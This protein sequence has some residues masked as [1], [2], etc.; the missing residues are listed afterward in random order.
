M[1]SFSDSTSS[2]GASAQAWP[3]QTPEV[4]VRDETFRHEVRDWLS[5][6]L[7][8]EFAGLR[9]LG[10]P[11]R[12]HEAFDLRVGWDRHLAASGWTCLGWPVE[13]GGR[14]LPLD[15][16]VVFH[17]EYARSGAPARVSH[18]GEELRG[19]LMLS[20]TLRAKQCQNK[21]LAR[22]QWH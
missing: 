9:G 12:E 4:L 5:A 8:G 10:G 2:A 18:L 11:G 6:N 7:A 16:Q 20:I 22:R 21:C 13:H 14:A 1:V 19:G 17:E 15:Q 3:P